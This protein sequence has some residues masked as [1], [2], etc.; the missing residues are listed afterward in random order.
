MVRQVRTVNKKK[1]NIKVDGQKKKQGRGGERKKRR[2]RK[3]DKEKK[4]KYRTGAM[5]KITAGPV[6][7]KMLQGELKCDMQ[8]G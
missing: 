3:S 7:G 5:Q 1:E 4:Q 6:I 8:A 2:K